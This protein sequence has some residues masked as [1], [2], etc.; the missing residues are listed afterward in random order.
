[1]AAQSES[2]FL[3]RWEQNTPLKRDATS[4]G[5]AY[6]GECK[7][8]GPGRENRRRRNEAEV[9]MGSDGCHRAGRAAVVEEGWTP[10]SGFTPAG[11]GRQRG[12]SIKATP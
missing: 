6:R 10:C 2:V 9:R 5:A 11:R 7:A 3:P 12:K 4:G 8:H 1:M